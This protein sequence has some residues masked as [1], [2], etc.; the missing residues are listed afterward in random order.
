M[1][2]S[3]WPGAAPGGSSVCSGWTLFVHRCC[4]GPRPPGFCPL[5]SERRWP[6]LRWSCG[7]IWSWACPRSR[8]HPPKTSRR[9]R[10]WKSILGKTARREQRRGQ[11]IERR[12]KENEHR[13]QHRGTDSDCRKI[14]SPTEEDQHLMVTEKWDSPSVNSQIK[15]QTFISNL[16]T[17]L[18]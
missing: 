10:R 14:T 18:F 13:L 1:A 8:S 11:E 15:K 4:T 2:A 17:L 3:R 9:R 16:L 7:R 6:S 5:R 12:R